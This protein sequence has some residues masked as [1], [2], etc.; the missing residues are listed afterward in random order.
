MKNTGQI[1]LL[2]VAFLFIGVMV[3]IYIGVANS[4]NYLDLSYNPDLTVSND[5]EIIKP[6]IKKININTASAEELTLLPGIGK[7][8]ANRIVDYRNENGP[9]FYIEDLSNVKGISKNTVDK[10]AKYI[11]VG[12]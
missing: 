5:N 4:H 9:F 12:G 6:Q 8:T 7:V 3:G 10:L 1:I 2:T 11:T